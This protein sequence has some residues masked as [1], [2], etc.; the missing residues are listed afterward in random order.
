MYVY[1]FKCILTTAMKNRSD[2]E[3]IQGFTYLT[4]YL[5][6]CGIN[7][8]FHFM[9]NEAST[10][11]NMKMTSMNIKYQLVPPSNHRANNAERLIQTFKNNFISVLCRV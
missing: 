11:L 8:G 1:D 10:S 2:K 3:I 5:K 9:D 6:R 7:Q 4:G